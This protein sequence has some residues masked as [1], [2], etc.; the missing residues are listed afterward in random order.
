[1]QTTIWKKN[2]NIP[3]TYSYRLKLHGIRSHQ[4]LCYFQVKQNRFTLYHVIYKLEI[5]EVPSV[6][7]LNLPRMH[8]LISTV[9][10]GTWDLGQLECCFWLILNFFTAKK[11]SNS[12]SYR[13][14][15]S[16]VHQKGSQHSRKTYL[17]NFSSQSMAA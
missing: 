1:M 6:F 11:V 5:I 8:L 2:P 13:V 10:V 4:L 14:V 12:H 9:L 16:K 17:S 3:F 15:T 7:A